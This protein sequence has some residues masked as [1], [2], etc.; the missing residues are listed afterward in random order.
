MH[1]QRESPRRHW[2]GGRLSC[3]GSAARLQVAAGPVGDPDSEQTLGSDL[4]AEGAMPA[5]LIANTVAAM[6]W[7]WSTCP[8]CRDRRWTG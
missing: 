8:E 7:A 1:T 6:L 3:D 2:T 4:P 5:G